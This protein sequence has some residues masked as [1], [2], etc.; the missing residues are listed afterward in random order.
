VKIW[1]RVFQRLLLALYRQ[2][3]PVL[4]VLLIAASAGTYYLW[5]DR[6][7][8]PNEAAAG[9]VQ[10]VEVTVQD[11][12]DLRVNQQGIPLVSATLTLKEKNGNRRIAM[13]IGSAEMLA[14][15]NERERGQLRPDQVP[16]AYDLMNDAISQFGGRV[17]R[18]IVSD[19][20]KDEFRAKVVLSS[21]GDVK[22]LNARPGDAV[23]LALK[24]KAPI[25]VEDKVLGTKGT[26]SG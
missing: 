19:V 22:V 15:L 18:V 12:T 9:G 11:L 1:G 5:L 10:P 7:N 23:A 14:I 16:Q 6:S 4:L 26:G 2:R 3:V 24:S 21:N 25:F 8:L 17:D 20:T 13:A